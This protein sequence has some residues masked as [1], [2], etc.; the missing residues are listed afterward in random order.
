MA[1][2]TAA[3]MVA[4]LGEREVIALTDRD[5]LGVVDETV[6]AAAL[7]KAS[8]E[9]DGYLAAGGYEVPLASPPS[10]L[11]IYC[12]DIA[13]YRLVGAAAV[14]TETARNRYKDAMKFLES[15]RDG[16]LKLGGSTTAPG[17]VVTVV[18]S[19]RIFTDD[20]LA[21]FTGG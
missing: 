3:D 9:I 18:G 16:R 5:N 13:R 14:E 2:A 12:C 4:Q 6:L 21:D 7:D 1:Y 20:T 11:A 17:G 19:S 15:V 8:A 10:I